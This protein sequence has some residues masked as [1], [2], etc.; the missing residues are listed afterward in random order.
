M[1]KTACTL[2][3]AAS[4][5]AFINNGFGQDKA[6]GLFSGERT[7]TGGAVVGVNMTQ[8]DGDGYGGYRKLGI[9]AGGIVYWNFLPKAGVSVELSYSRKG[10]RGIDE[11]YSP[12]A[13][14]YF[15]KYYLKMNY[16]EVP[17]IF[18]YYVKPQYHFGIGAAYTQLINTSEYYEGIDTYVFDP[19]EFPFKKYGVDVIGSI[20]YVVYKGFMLDARFQY[21]LISAR[22]QLKAPISSGNS[23]GQRHNVI[24]IRLIK[25]F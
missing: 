24:A 20:S 19:A 4:L 2:W 22:D 9:N 6:N 14:P 18:H 7:F 1:F 25:L 21:S 3:I 13:G 10:S 17:V 16:A 5:L 12:Y 15:G 8:V 11:S 23:W